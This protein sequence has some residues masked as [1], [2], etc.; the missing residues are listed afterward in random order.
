MTTQK[1]LRPYTVTV[2][3]IDPDLWLRIRKAAL[4]R[5]CPAGKIVNQ[6]L[7]AWL[8]IKKGEAK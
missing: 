5:G 2:R 1:K 7:T 4:E 6:A 3:G 8:N